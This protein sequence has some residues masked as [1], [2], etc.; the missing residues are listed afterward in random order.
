MIDE[1]EDW[2]GWEDGEDTVELCIYAQPQLIKEV[3]PRLF[4]PENYSAE[5]DVQLASICVKLESEAKRKLCTLPTCKVTGSFIH[6]RAMRRNE[7]G[8]YVG[9][10]LVCPIC[11]G[12]D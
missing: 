11:S 6:I 9:A 7:H 8:A 1:V 10:F 12:E 3:R 2:G 4:F 5:E